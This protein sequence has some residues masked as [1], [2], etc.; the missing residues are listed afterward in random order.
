M[1]ETAETQFDMPKAYEPGKVEDKWYQ[2]WMEKGYFKPKIDPAKE[3]LHHHHAAAQRHRRA[4]RRPRPDRH[5]GR[6]HDPLA[7]HEG[8]SHPLAARRRPRRHRRPGGGRKAAG[9]RK[10]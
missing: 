3:T 6:Y 4:A 8:R 1:S 5:A 10:D 7:P 9:Q 2:F